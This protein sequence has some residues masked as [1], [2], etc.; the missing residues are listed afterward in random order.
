MSRRRT[1]GWL[2]LVSL[3]GAYVLAI[4]PLPE[5]AQPARPLWVALV[6]LFWC[7]ETPDRTG[8]G[9]AWLAGLGL[10]L[11]T[12]GLLGEHALRMTIMIYIAQR[13]RRR[14][15]FYP[16]WQQALAVLALLVNDRIVVLWIQGVLDQPWPDWRFW[17]GPLTGMLFW[18]LTFLALDALRQRFR[19]S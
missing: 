7:L 16:P 13:F 4:A 8:I 19:S 17:L 3:L 1:P 15:R 10:D 11:V 14:L 9:S 12:G 2:I 18:P 6:M 5:W